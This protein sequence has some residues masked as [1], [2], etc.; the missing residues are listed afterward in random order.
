[1]VIPLRLLPIGVDLINREEM[2]QVARANRYVNQRTNED[3]DSDSASEDGIYDER[4]S[5]RPDK[6]VRPVP[7]KPT[8]VSK[9]SERT[10][11]S[12]A[13]LNAMRKSKEMTQYTKVTQIMKRKSSKIHNTLIKND[14]A[15]C[16]TL[17]ARLYPPAG[18]M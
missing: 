15:K 2:R 18:P 11:N 4:K 8:G 3:E 14:I 1:M 12:L 9:R 17:L 7:A 13:F 6:R 10:L 5:H 16:S